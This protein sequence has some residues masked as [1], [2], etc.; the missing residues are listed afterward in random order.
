MKLKDLLQRIKGTYWIIKTNIR[1]STLS[2]FSLTLAL[3]LIVIVMTGPN[4]AAD[5]LLEENLKEKEFSLERS[6]YPRNLEDFNYENLINLNNTVSD[7]INE[8]QISEPWLFIPQR[9]ISGGSIRI[10]SRGSSL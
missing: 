4:A 2:A 8:Y 5:L 3:V 1:S 10:S 7:L 9:I 6:L